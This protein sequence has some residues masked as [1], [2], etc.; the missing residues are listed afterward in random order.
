MGAL[1]SGIPEEDLPDIVERW[2]RS[3]GSIVQFWYDVERAA[4]AAVTSGACTRVGRVLISVRDVAHSRHLVITLPSGR[5]LFYA[6][7]HWT[8][9]RFGKPSLAYMGMDQ[10][11][12]RWK[13]I[14]TYGGKLVENITQAVARDCLFY[15]MEQLEAQGFPIVFDIHDEVVIE[16]DADRADLDEVVRIMSQPPPWADGLPLNADGWVGEYFH[17]D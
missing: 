9:N 7:P 6:D 11:A 16:V 4:S 14:E 1:R 3:N 13:S 8:E 2:R 12:K 15:A 5:E 17:K 10:S